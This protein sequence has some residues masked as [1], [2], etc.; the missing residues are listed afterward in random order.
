LLDPGEIRIFP[1]EG[2]DD[3]NARKE[4]LE[5][6]GTLIGEDHRPLAEKQQETH[7]PGLYRYHE[8]E[9]GETSRSARTQVDQ[10]DGQT[11]YQLDRSGP[12]HVEDLAGE[13]DARDVGG[14]VIDQF[15]AGAD[16]AS[17]SGEGKSLL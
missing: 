2:F 1:G 8:G 12:A 13:V 3:L 11:N 4:L 15:S 9:D 10:E 6:F 7:Q 17:T 5:K 16:M 14:Y